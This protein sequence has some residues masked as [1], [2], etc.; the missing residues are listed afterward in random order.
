MYHNRLMLLIIGFSVI[1]LKICLNFRQQWLNYYEHM[2]LH[3]IRKRKSEIATHNRCTVEGRKRRYMTWH[4]V[5]GGR[6]TPIFTILTNYVNWLL[7]TF[8]VSI[9]LVNNAYE[10]WYHVT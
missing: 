4:F 10:L 3:M 2:Y 6:D 1:S 8:T 7:C 5:R 9:T